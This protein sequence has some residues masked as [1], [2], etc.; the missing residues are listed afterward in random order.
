MRMSNVKAATANINGAIFNVRSA[1]FAADTFGLCSRND[2]VV[3]G[4]DVAEFW[5]G[6]TATHP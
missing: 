3:K 4:E 6:F 2:E 1:V 5:A